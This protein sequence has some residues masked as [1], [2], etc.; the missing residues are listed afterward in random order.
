MNFLRKEMELKRV[1][2]SIDIITGQNQVKINGKNYEAEII[3]S[4]DRIGNS[5]SVK[6][7]NKQAERRFRKVAEII[8]LS[9]LKYF[10][11]P[12]DL[13][14]ICRYPVLGTEL[15]DFILNMSISKE[16]TKKQFNVVSRKVTEFDEKKEKRKGGKTY[17]IDNFCEVLNA[18]IKYMD[19]DRLLIVA[20]EN[21]YQLFVNAPDEK[22]Y[23]D[24]LRLKEFSRKVDRVLENKNMVFKRGKVGAPEVTSYENIMNEID[25]ILSCYINTE[26]HTKEEVLQIRED[27]LKGKRGYATIS[28]LDYAN[29]M[30]FDRNELLR[31]VE[32]EPEALEYFLTTGL[33]DEKVLKEF[34]KTEKVINSNVALALYNNGL[35]STEDLLILYSDSK[36][37]LESIKL[38]KDS[39][40]KPEELEAIVSI[41]ELIELYNV[42]DKKEE[43]ERYRRLF[44]LLKIDGK[45]IDEQNDLGIQILDSSNQLLDDETIIDLYK[46]GIITCDLLV[47]FVNSSFENLYVSGELKPSDVRRL[48][49]NG[50]ID[51][52]KLKVLLLKMTDEEKMVSVFSTFP[53]KENAT[54]RKEL[55]SNLTEAERS[56]HEKS[57]KSGIVKKEKQDKKEDE[58][59]EEFETDPCARWSLIAEL[60][61]EYSQKLLDDGTLRVYLPNRGKYIIEKLFD[62]K[63]RTAYGAATYILDENDFEQNQADIIQQN[64]VN[65]SRLVELSKANLAKKIIHK[66]WGKAICKEFDIENPKLY[67]E[68][69]RNLIKQLAD[70]VEKSKQPREK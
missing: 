60:D 47:D 55:L 51:K 23:E 20:L 36:I 63:H 15:R 27:I 65:R 6:E 17:S 32:Q 13:I 3:T 45:S 69:R 33:V 11:T 30:K 61:E 64:K 35:I 25:E 48:F 39:I 1:L 31:I 26:E 10:L 40:K 53:G 58:T 34:I 16:D 21:Y 28:F 43:F 24:A 4:Q 50:I 12:S 29:A 44:K 62:S 67:T 54:L 66:G 46:K 14:D 59:H 22:K 68:E 18:N 2:K 37:S 49:D 70:E 41:D 9:E 38:I 57:V 42:P 8:P 56:I 5:K 52:E 19:I 7:K